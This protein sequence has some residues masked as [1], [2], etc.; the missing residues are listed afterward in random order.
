MPVLFDLPDPVAALTAAQCARV[1]STIAWTCEQVFVE[2]AGWLDSIPKPETKVGLS[3]AA[4]VL[5]WHC[6]QWRALVPESVLLEDDRQAAPGP[7][8]RGAVADLAGAEP[9]GRVRALCEL[10]GRMRDEIDL[11]T[12]RLSPVSD[13]AAAR[14]SSVLRA[15]LGRVTELLDG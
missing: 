8:A 7:A 12:A 4:R 15:D 10:A 13:G 3:V 11:L 14:L 6:D 2:V 1:Y 9:A 5:A